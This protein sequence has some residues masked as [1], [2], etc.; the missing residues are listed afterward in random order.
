MV[1]VGEAC[2]WH[3]YEYARDAAQ[4]GRKKAVLVLGHVGSERDGMAYIASLLAARL[5]DVEFRYFD[6][7]EVYTYAD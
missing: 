2:E 3:H 1:V 5:P 4:L 6:C 7:G